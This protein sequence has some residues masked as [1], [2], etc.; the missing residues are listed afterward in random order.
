MKT[1]LFLLAVTTIP[2]CL[3]AGTIGGSDIVPSTTLES[4]SP[5]TINQIA[6]GLAVDGD[7]DPLNGFVS[8]AS[9]GTITLDLVGDFDLNGFILSNDVNVLSEGIKDFRLD[10]YDSANALITSSAILVGPLG[11]SAPQ[12]Y[13]FAVVHGVSKVN[14]VVLN[15]HPT[16]L[17]RI[18]IREVAFLGTRI[19]NDSGTIQAA[20][21]PSIEIAWQSVTGEIYQVQVTSSLSAPAWTNLGTSVMGDGSEMSVYDQTRNREKRFYCV[22]KLQ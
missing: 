20:A 12:I 6:D 4:V 8:D 13:T 7:T 15:C 1:L 18:E 22:V 21:Y 10:F 11:Q 17:N 3:R 16:T 19:G 14:L 9:S 2:L 5:W